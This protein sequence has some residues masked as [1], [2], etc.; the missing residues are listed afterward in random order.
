[1]LQHKLIGKYQINCI[2]IAGPFD[3]DAFYTLL[4][5][6]LEDSRVVEKPMPVLFDLR[7]ADF[8]NLNLPEIRQHLMK[9][10]ALGGDISNFSCAYLVGG[11]NSYS[12]VRMASVFSELTGILPEDRTLISASFT[13]SVSW[14]AELLNEDAGDITRALKD[15]DVPGEQLAAKG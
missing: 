6:L 12:F 9:V 2:Q 15:A 4:R 10:A 1:M 3:L 13:D 8:S 14:I 5:R 7:Q 11:D